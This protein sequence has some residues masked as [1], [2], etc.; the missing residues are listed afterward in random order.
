M[1]NKIIKE[2]RSNVDGFKTE[3]IKKGIANI[4]RLCQVYGRY[5]HELEPLLFPMTTILRF[6]FASFRREQWLIGPTYGILSMQLYIEE[7]DFEKLKD[8]EKIV[9]ISDLIVEYLCRLF[10]LYGLDTQRIYDAQA[11][12]QANGFYIKHQEHKNRSC[13]TVC[14]LESLN[15]YSE[16]KYRLAYQNLGE[17]VRK[18]VF[19][20]QQHYDAILW[21]KLDIHEILLIPQFFKELKWKNKNEF[22]MVWGN[23]RYIF[24]LQNEEIIKP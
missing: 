3:Y 4:T 11:K 14:W 5:M 6:D 13:K 23:D 18:I 10:D 7:T 21:K 8:D 22:V 16:N 15:G 17:E 9:F 20:T 24:N 1:G 12:I 19:F 2:F